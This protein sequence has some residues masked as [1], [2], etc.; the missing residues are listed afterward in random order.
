MRLFEI[1]ETNKNEL[2]VES[3]KDLKSSFERA[4]SSL[5]RTNSGEEYRF[6][7][8]A[9]K[10]I[11]IDHG[12]DSPTNCFE[13]FAK[14]NYF[15]KREGSPQEFNTFYW[16]KKFNSLKNE[17]LAVVVLDFFGDASYSDRE[18]IKATEGEETWPVL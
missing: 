7:L 15:D 3:Y 14:N 13:F 18:E 4:L 6:I 9:L 11:K 17:E 8:N 5:N 2:I 10:F 1:F 16:I 12:F